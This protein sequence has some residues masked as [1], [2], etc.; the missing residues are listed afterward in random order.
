VLFRS[1]TIPFVNAR[2]H[3]GF[4]LE[5]VQADVLARYHRLRGHSVR[6]QTGT[7]ENALKNVL[8]ALGMIGSG[9]IITVMGCGGDR[10]TTKR[11]VMGREAAAGSDVVV[12]TSDNPRT[13]DPMHI[14]RQVEEGVRG[15]GYAPLEGEEDGKP[16]CERGYRVIPDRREAIGWAVRNLRSDDILLVAGKGH[17]TYQ[18][19]NGVR[20]PFDDRDVVTEEVNRLTRTSGSSLSAEVHTSKPETNH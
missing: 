15:F 13:E 20:Y 12:V 6:L 4:A 19:I 7:D 17:E 18:E 16:L 9:R 2:P 14:I 8:E 3:I 1:T 11:P 5:L 10:D